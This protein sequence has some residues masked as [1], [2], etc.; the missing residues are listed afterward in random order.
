[1]ALD[2]FSTALTNLESARSNFGAWQSRIQFAVNNLSTKTTE[3]KA[4][5]S[6][7]VDADVAAD[8]AELTRRSIVQQ[9]GTAILA[10]AN[11]IPALVLKLLS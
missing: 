7:I 1:M 5:E 9:E 10:Q 2:T 11:Q 6:R 8:V 4:A 3:Y